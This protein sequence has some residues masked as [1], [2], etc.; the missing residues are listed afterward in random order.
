[1][2][3][4]DDRVVITRD[5]ADLST[6]GTRVYVTGPHF[7]NTDDSVFSSTADRAKASEFQRAHAERLLRK[8]KWASLNPEIV[9]V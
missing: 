7:G 3:G 9:E 6:K 2:S 8:G 4:R 1:M 5:S